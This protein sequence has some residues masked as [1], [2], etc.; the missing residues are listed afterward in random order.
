M[1]ID[2]CDTFPTAHQNLHNCKAYFFTA[3]VLEGKTELGC[4]SHA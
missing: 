1:N 3:Q 4:M 2:V